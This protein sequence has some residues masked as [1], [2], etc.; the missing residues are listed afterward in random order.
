MF[1][2]GLVYWESDK[3]RTVALSTAEAEYMSVSVASHEALAFGRPSQCLRIWIP[4]PILLTDNQ[5][6]IT[7][8]ES[9]VHHQIAKA[10]C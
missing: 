5:A 10:S 1:N 4:T 8:A 3:Q 6:A 9:T 2:N 7:I